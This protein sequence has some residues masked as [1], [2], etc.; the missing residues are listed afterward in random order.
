MFYPGVGVGQPLAGDDGAGPAVIDLLRRSNLPPGV[1]LS[2]VREPTALFPLLDEDGMRLVIVDAVVAE[3]AGQILDLDA[4][5]IE[6]R[7]LS[8]VSSHGISVGEALAL[9]RTTGISGRQGAD[10]RLVAIT[11]A[12]PVR[13]AIGLSAAVAAAIPQAAH[14]ALE[15]VIRGKGG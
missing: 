2:N 8:S 9:A 1:V 7:C 5:E 3:P 12:H 10:V 15:R 4:A 11:I 13:G 14:L 6:S